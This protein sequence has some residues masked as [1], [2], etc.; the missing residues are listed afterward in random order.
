MELTAWTFELDEESSHVIFTQTQRE[1]VLPLRY[2]VVFWVLLKLA[3]GSVLLVQS[4]I[5]IKVH[6]ILQPELQICCVQLR[7]NKSYICLVWNSL[8]F[9]SASLSISL[10]EIKCFILC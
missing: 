10:D 1:I 2:N 4:M 8:S 7:I 9:I 6:Y 3:H 5:L